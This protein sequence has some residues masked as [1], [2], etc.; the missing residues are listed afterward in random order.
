[1]CDEINANI[2]EMYMFKELATI[3]MAN[4]GDRFY[5]KVK[6]IYCCNLLYLLQSTNIIA[7]INR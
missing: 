1:M 6:T 3:T 5:Y 4:S 2:I 7:E